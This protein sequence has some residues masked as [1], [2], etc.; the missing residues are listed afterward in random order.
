VPR[1]THLVS[2]LDDG[3]RVDMHDEHSIENTVLASVDITEICHEA[4]MLEV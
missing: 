2:A 4:N 1:A 3:N